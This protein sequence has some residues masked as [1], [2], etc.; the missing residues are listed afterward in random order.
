MEELDDMSS[1]EFSEWQVFFGMEPRGDARADFNTAQVLQLLANI[2]RG[3]N[4]A[5]YRLRD[6]YPQR[7][8]WEKSEETEEDEARRLLAQFEVLERSVR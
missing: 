7:W 3:R 2:N 1:F 8:P 5:A 4:Q 6:F